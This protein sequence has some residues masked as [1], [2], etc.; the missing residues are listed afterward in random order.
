MDRSLYIIILLFLLT[1]NSIAA[2][3][4]RITGPKTNDPINPG[5]P[6]KITGNNVIINVNIMLI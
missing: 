5:E 3:S 2:Q 6:I 4:L 1:F